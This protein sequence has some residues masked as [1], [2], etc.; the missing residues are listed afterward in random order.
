MGFDL[1]VYLF[2]FALTSVSLRLGLR[3]LAINWLVVKM[4]DSMGSPRIRCQCESRILLI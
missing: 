3:L 2:V 1:D 4:V